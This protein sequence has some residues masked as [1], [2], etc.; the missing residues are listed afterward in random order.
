M[1]V[2]KPV[3]HKQ[4][5]KL[6]TRKA[7]VTVVAAATVATSFTV[8]AGF[9]DEFY[10]SAGAA[11]NVTP[12]Q[13]YTTQTMGVVS[14]G[15]VVWRSPQR[16]FQPL[17][18]TP[19]SLKA[20]C[21]GIDF[22]LGAFGLA[23]K[24]QFVQFLRN[25]GQNAAGLAFK[26]ALQAMA[27]ELESKITEVANYINEWN[28]YFGNSCAAASA[29]MDKGPNEWI[30]NTVQSAKL[31]LLSSGQSG[32]IS[33]A[34]AEVNTNAGR[35]IAVAPVKTNSAG[36]V[37]MAPELNILWAAFNSGEMAGLSTSEK[38]LMM[39]L[40]GTTI[41]RKVGEGEDATIKAE[42][43]PE[44]INVAKLVGKTTD[45]TV[46]LETYTCQGDSDKCMSVSTTTISEKPFAVA[47]YEK[48]SRLK[49]A[50]IDRQAP[51]LN[52]LKALTVTTSV[53]IYKIISI[54]ALPSRPGFADEIIRHYSDII[55]WEIATRYVDD[56][57]RNIQ[58]MLTTSREQD[59]DQQKIVALERIQDRLTTIRREMQENRV[60]IYAQIQRIG[61]MTQNLEL[62]ER[63]LYGSMSSQL[64]ANMSFGR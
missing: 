2:K 62:M 1:K 27:P 48:A 38:E 14:G 41:M 52:D 4:S 30:R 49:D 60:D 57:S 19:P 45:S 64:A 15:G 56:M 11:A 39:A 12:A 36:K 53:P 26:V 24:Q 16:N 13:A 21:G 42:P 3:V 33:D 22:F 25:V 35:A 51:D 17:Y 29:L 34:E 61:A 55:G 59:G 32:D 6:F 63:A 9:L 5:L 58:Q 8:S 7:I 44:K 40:V 46:Q 31:A 37:I 54:S 18:F 47:V 28:K 50:I 43:Y 23:N 20:G 10:D